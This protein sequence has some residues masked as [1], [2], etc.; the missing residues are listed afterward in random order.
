MH[1]LSTLV[2]LM[3]RR[4]EVSGWSYGPSV[5]RNT[6]LVAPQI[7]LHMRWTAGNACPHCCVW[8]DV[9]PFVAEGVDYVVD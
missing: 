1:V 6:Q 8:M 2:H 3:R 4:A 9:S 7:D 5:R